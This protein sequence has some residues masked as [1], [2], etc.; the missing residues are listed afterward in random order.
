MAKDPNHQRTGETALG[1]PERN[2]GGGNLS[3]RSIGARLAS[4]IASAVGGILM[5]CPISDVAAQSGSGDPPRSG[6]YIGGGIGANWASDL[7]QEAGTGRRPA[8]RQPLLSMRTPF[9][10]SPDTAGVTISTLPPEPYSVW[11]ES[12]PM[13]RHGGSS[14]PDRMSKPA[15]ASA[16]ERCPPG[17]SRVRRSQ[18]TG[19]DRF[20]VLDDHLRGGVLN[21]PRTRNASRCRT[22]RRTSTPP[23]SSVSTMH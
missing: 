1:D 21:A 5:L 18:P 7:D 20:A 12:H 13:R 16:V 14:V 3:P 8:I 11:A 10:K 17:L 22:E 15:G 9:P 2:P 6:W 4:F 23:N 19:A